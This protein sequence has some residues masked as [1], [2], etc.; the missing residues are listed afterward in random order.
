MNENPAW[1]R[2]GEDEYEKDEFE[3]KTMMIMMMPNRTVWKD[4][5]NIDK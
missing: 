3:T 5:I 2:K 4:D 1:S